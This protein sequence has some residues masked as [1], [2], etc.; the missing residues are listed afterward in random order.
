M[1][2]NEKVV[3]EATCYAGHVD[4][5]VPEPLGKR[6]SD[7]EVFRWRLFSGE[8]E[9]F[10]CIEKSWATTDD[11][12]SQDDLVEPWLYRLGLSTV[13]WTHARAPRLYWAGD[14]DSRTTLLIEDLGDVSDP[15]PVIPYFHCKSNLVSSR[16]SQMVQSLVE[17]NFLVRDDG[18]SAVSGRRIDQ[19]IPEFCRFNSTFNRR[20]ERRVGTI[21]DD[22]EKGKAYVNSINALAKSAAKERK[23][24]VDYGVCCHC[25]VHPGNVYIDD[26][27]T[28]ILFD[29]GNAVFGYPGIDLAQYAASS[30]ALMARAVEKCN[31]MQARLDALVNLY[32]EKAAKFSGRNLKKELLAWVF[33]DFLIS[34]AKKVRRG[35]WGSAGTR[36]MVR[37]HYRIADVLETGDL[38]KA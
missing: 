35:P 12:S 31:E 19:V 21:F 26:K 13:S 27:S 33:R 9:V 17:F 8:Q 5:V 29:F 10:S 16:M 6:F 36:E 38:A 15:T 4:R 37:L 18:K 24:L 11:D 1:P 30:I 7:A 2:L 3:L 32:F 22:P 28:L 23:A 14:P 20:V 25:D 34:L